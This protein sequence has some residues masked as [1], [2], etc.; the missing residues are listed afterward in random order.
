MKNT[1]LITGA[2]GFIGANLVRNLVEQ[3]QQVSI[4]VRDKKLNWRLSD[5]SSKLDIFECDIQDVKLAQIVDKIKP[6]YIFHLARYGNLPHEDNVDKMIDINLKGTINLI[7]AAKQNPFKL[8]INAGS[9]DEYGVKESAMRETDLPAPVT[10]NG[11]IKSAI[12]FYCQKEAT[13]NN[14]P[15]I[16]FRIFTP[17]GYFEDNFRLI[18]SIIENSIENASVKVSIPTSVRDFIFIEDVVDAY[19]HAAKRKHN[20][21]EIY[22]IGSGKQHT[23]GEIVQ[24][25][26]GITKSKSSVKWG[27]VAKQ[28]RY[29]EPLRWEA[30]MSKTKSV[31]QWEA[32]NTMESGLRKT[33]EWFKKNKNV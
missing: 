1:F 3:K 33:V 27:A 22:N 24:M 19:M 32:R 29:I 5:L 25:I 20:P 10:N 28:A 15:I 14:L 26:Q 7:N 31:L 9:G 16:T 8:F 4:I 17:Y 13:R 2:T 6:D 23:V 21:G 18:P 30:N 11:V 12:T